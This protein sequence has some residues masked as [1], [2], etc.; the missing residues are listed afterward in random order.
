MK[1]SKLFHWLYASL[2]FLPLLVIPIFAIY[3]RNESNTFENNIEL[4]V[5]QNKVVDFNQY[6]L[7]EDNTRSDS[8]WSITTDSN[9]YAE[10]S[11]TS[12]PSNLYPRLWISNNNFNLGDKIYIKTNTITTY[13]KIGVRGHK[14]DN[15]LDYITWYNRVVSLNADYDYIDM[16]VSFLTDSDAFNFSSYFNLFNFT[17]MFGVGNEPT[18]E[19]FNTWYDSFYSYNTGEKQLLKTGVYE[20]LNN[21]DIGS[22]FLYSVYQPINDYFNI[23]DWMNLGG[24]YDWFLLNIFNGSNSIVIPIVFNLMVY[25]LAVSFIWLIFDVLMYVPNM[26]HK[27]LDK[28]RLE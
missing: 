21:T 1:L 23:K 8:V 5:E 24:L 20:T 9:N 12:I 18:I 6:V 22:Q 28:A 11:F 26:I 27:M 13:S 3:T 2:M 25:W 7:M 10:V 4:Q 15:T 19:Q 17:Q 14:A 16:Y